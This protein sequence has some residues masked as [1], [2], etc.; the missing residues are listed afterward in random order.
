MSQP[1]DYSL[2]PA[3]RDDFAFAEA[4]Y[5]N[6]M[7]PLMQV[8][9][10]WDEPRR[11]AGIRRSFKA[12]DACIIICDGRE[13]GWTQVIER[14]ADYNLAQIQIVEDYCGRGIGTDFLNQLLARAAREEK[15]VSLSAVRSNRAIALYLRMGFQ[16]ID[17]SATPIIEMV[18]APPLSGA[19]S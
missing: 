1:P 18:W 7:R 2:R 15:T 9:D 14:D 19:R 11:R 8:L 5:I 17:P 4:I 6:A 12:D 10:A 16:I 3:R 13:I